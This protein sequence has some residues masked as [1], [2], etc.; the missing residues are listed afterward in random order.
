MGRKSARA[1]PP[2]A[3][4][5]LAMLRSAA[6]AAGLVPKGISKAPPTEYWNALMDFA[7]SP[8]NK[9]IVATA[10]AAAMQAQRHKEEI[11]AAFPIGKGEPDWSAPQYKALKP[12]LLEKYQELWA[13]TVPTLD[14][15]Q[16]LAD[17]K[18]ADFAKIK[19]DY[20]AE[21]AEMIPAPRP[22]WLSWPRRR[23]SSTL[24]G[25]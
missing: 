11:E 17:A 13:K 20:K 23:R 18:K 3:P 19:A 8:E 2:A 22:S 24:C 1:C 16:T 4:R 25:R 10:Q 21:V 5:A 9:K 14:K 6:R 12:D 7:R 15:L